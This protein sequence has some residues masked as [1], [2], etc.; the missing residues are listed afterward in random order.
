MSSAL[1][2][3]RF[4]EGYD[5]H[6]QEAADFGAQLMTDAEAIFR[7]KTNTEWLDLL[8]DCRRPRRTGPF[9]RGDVRPPP[10]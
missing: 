4:D 5:Q 3:I 7:A 6:S 2:D 1:H 8:D 10:G 9:R